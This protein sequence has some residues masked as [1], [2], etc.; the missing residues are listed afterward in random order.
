MPCRAARPGA[1]SS[2]P[3]RPG[4]R[5]RRDRRGRR[6][7]RAAPRRGRRGARGGRTPPRRFPAWHKDGR[8]SVGPRGGQDTR[9]PSQRGVPWGSEGRRPSVPHPGRRRR[10]PRGAVQA[11]HGRRRSRGPRRQTSRPDPAGAAGRFRAVRYVRRRGQT[12]AARQ[13]LDEGVK[14][15][16]RRFP[17]WADAWQDTDVDQPGGEAALRPSRRDVHRGGGMD[18]PPF[19]T[20]HRRRLL[21]HLRGGQDDPRALAGVQDV[22]QPQRVVV[23]RQEVPPRP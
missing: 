21:L 11:R 18:V 16:Q 20:P 14:T 5:T 12:Q 17:C 6:S 10:R 2:P 23:L 7:A 13:I 4:R 8:E 1:A 3:S 9:G 22:G 19:R 15:L